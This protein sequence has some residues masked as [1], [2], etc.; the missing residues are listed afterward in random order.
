MMISYKENPHV[1]SGYT[2]GNSALF[3]IYGSIIW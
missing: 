2:S 3:F 1:H